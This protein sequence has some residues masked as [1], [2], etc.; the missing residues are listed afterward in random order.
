MK[1]LTLGVFGTSRKE[2]EKRVPIHPEHLAWIEPEVRKNLYFEKGYGTPFGYTDEYLKS[3]SGDILEREYLF[4]I[5]DI[6]L[7]PK[8][9]Q[10]DFDQ[11]KTG[12]I[13]WG[14]PHCVQ[15]HSFTQTA[16]DRKLTLIAWESMHRWSQHGDW[17][18]HTFHKNN[19]LAGYCG[20]LH[21]LS[22]A[23]IDGNY[24]PHRKAVV[25]SFGS[26]SR[27]ATYALQAMGFHDITIF[28]QRYSTFV[29]D[30][31]VGIEYFHFEQT[32]EGKLISLH[33]DR[34]E[35]PFLEELKQADIIVN[36]I[37]QNTDHPLTFVTDDEVDQL[38]NGFLIVDISC[39][40]G[41]GFEFARPTTFKEPIFKVSNGYYYGVD[42]TPSYLWNSASW[43]I[44]KSLLP[45][46]PI[47]MKGPESWAK[48]NTISK[49]IEIQNGEILNP[50]IITFQHR[51]RE[52]P[53]KVIT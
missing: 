1:Y 5:C 25:I 9:V 41:M 2:D 14:W 19:E 13:L 48:N 10:A 32:E 35:Y 16:I 21:A 29:A 37:L 49:A 53:Y 45:Y 43:E 47:V 6:Q 30:Q 3:K 33:P 42:H 18:M 36:G 23:G 28:T 38:K 4:E 20:V 8:P 46:L 50:K 22:L 7:L 34:H 12:C 52:Y 24:G 51:N 44:S 15:Q 11:M 39:D 40:K 27:G 17:Q 26:V 31:F